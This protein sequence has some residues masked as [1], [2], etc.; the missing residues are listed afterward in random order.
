MPLIVLDIPKLVDENC[1]DDDSDEELWQEESDEDAERTQCLFS[2]KEFPA[3]DDAISYLKITYNF[4][5]AELKLKHQMD[6][7]SYMKVCCFSN[8]N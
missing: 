2:D 5:L 7:Y 6:F 8:K 3:L 4:D 1:S